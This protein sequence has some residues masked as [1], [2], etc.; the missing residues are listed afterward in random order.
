[1]PE[2]KTVCVQF[3]DVSTKLNDILEQPNPLITNA[4]KKRA[5][6]NNLI[7]AQKFEP[8]TQKK[9]K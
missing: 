8:R 2:S 9:T 7:D 6:N 4:K 5:S 1:M 3:S